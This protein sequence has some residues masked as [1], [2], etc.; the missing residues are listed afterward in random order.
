M[1]RNQRTTINVNDKRINVR[2]LGKG[3]W[4]NAYYEEGVG[5]VFLNVRR[6]RGRP[7][8]GTVD[9][10][11]NILS[12]C[13]YTPHLPVVEHCGGVKGNEWFLSP[14]YRPLKAA[15]TKA[16]NE[17]KA[18]KAAVQ[19]V[20]YGYTYL[21]KSTPYKMY[22]QLMTVVSILESKNFADLA[23]AVETLAGHAANYATW[24]FEVAPRNSG[25]GFDGELILLDCLFVYGE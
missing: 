14:I 17:Y 6:G 16:W 22:S 10:S 7:F 18:L 19:E 4:T 20:T 1:K 2:Y 5:R 23:M 11:K 15:S 21:P 13:Q 25:V 8:G 24:G 12:N 3:T 9:Y